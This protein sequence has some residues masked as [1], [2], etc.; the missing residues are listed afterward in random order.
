MKYLLPMKKLLSIVTLACCAGSLAAQ[1]VPPMINYQGQLLNSDATPLPTSD[2]SLTFNIYDAVQGGNLVWG[3]QIFDGR[4]GPGFG[5]RIPVV[6]GYFNVILGP[7]D[8]NGVQLSEAFGVPS[9]YLEIT[10]S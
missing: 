8:T 4:S 2:Y 6:Q 5:A 7:S 1:P 3:P 9:R 10:I